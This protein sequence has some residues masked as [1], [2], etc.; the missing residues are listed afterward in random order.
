MAS[1]WSRQSVQAHAEQSSQGERT[2]PFPSV[3]RRGGVRES[4]GAWPMGEGAWLR[5]GEAGPPYS[6]RP[7]TRGAASMSTG[8]FYISSLLEK[9]TSSDKDFRCA[10]R[11][12]GIRLQGSQPVPAAPLPPC[13]PL[14]EPPS[15]SPGPGSACCPAQQPRPQPLP[16]FAALAS[17]VPR[18]GRPPGPSVKSPSASPWNPCN[19]LLTLVE[20]GLLCTTS[21]QGYLPRPTLLPGL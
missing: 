2:R 4:E 8:A 9:M 7:A 1:C 21:I 10:L 16:A 14:W 3:L 20:T 13:R 12:L 17:Q 19:S 11:R 6:I 18:T 5:G 15:T